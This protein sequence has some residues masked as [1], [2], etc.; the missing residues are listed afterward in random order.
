LGGLNVITY[1]NM[2]LF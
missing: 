1:L 2:S